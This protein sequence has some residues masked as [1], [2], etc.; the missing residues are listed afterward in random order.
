[1]HE[2][3]L[4]VLFYFW[5][6][7]LIENSA[8]HFFQAWVNCFLWMKPI[9]GNEK[10]SCFYHHEIF[11]EQAMFFRTLFSAKVL[12]FKWARFRCSWNSTYLVFFLLKQDPLDH[13]HSKSTPDSVYSRETNRIEENVISCFSLFWSVWFVLYVIWPCFG[14][15]MMSYK[16]S[17]PFICCITVLAGAEQPLKNV[18]F[19]LKHLF[20]L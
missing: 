11:K 10:G 12:A 16:G 4:G 3:V 5:V 2:V 14:I 17:S 9:Y 7:Y 18:L 19:T 15:K 1:M 6:N 13:L 8:L 20:S